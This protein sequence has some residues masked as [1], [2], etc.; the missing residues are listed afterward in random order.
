MLVVNIWYIST[1]KYLKMDFHHTHSWCLANAHKIYIKPIIEL[2]H[3]L[4]HIVNYFV[5]VLITRQS[6][7]CFAS[8]T[9]DILNHLESEFSG[10]SDG[11]EM[12]DHVLVEDGDHSR[13]ESEQV[14]MS[15]TQTIYVESDS[16]TS[17]GSSS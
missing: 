13:N 16:S 5:I 9:M 2:L 3:C 11:N 17:S 7:C 10:D 15:S 6:F 1:H 12:E 14:T 8:P 4:A